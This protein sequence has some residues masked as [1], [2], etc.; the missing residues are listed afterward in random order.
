M[1]CQPGF[2]HLSGLVM[3]V[4]GTTITVGWHRQGRHHLFIA[5][6]LASVLL[7]SVAMQSPGALAA[8]RE[9]AVLPLPKLTTPSAP[10]PLPADLPAVLPAGD[11]T[12]YHRIFA[13]Q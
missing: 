12:L 7:G 3:T 5:S 13:A 9:T 10:A 6:V 11:V 1:A 8:P 2:N 4:I